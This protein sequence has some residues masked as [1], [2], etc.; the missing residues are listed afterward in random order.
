MRVLIIEKNENKREVIRTLLPDNAIVDEMLTTGDAIFSTLDM[1]DKI[2]LTR[3]AIYSGKSFDFLS[4]YKENPKIFIVD[5]P[6][7]KDG[8]I[9]LSLVCGLRDSCQKGI[10]AVTLGVNKL[11]LNLHMGNSINTSLFMEYS[12]NEKNVGVTVL[13]AG[14]SVGGEFKQAA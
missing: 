6:R 13:Y 5:L 10:K 7:G 1:F 14:H 2:I 3:D 4:M 8:F 12:G 11:D 9:K